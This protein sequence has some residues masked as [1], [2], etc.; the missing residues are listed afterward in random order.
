MPNTIIVPI[1]ESGAATRVLPFAVRLADATTSSIAL[2]QAIPDEGLREHAEMALQRV[3]WH[4]PT[5]L[6]CTMCVRVGSP[7]R[8]IV[9]VA[10]EVHACLI[11][12]ATQHPAEID[13]W[14]NGSIADEVL[15]VARVP[16]LIVPPTM[17]R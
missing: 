4:I 7:T 10:G 12:M 13:R 17:T 9:E 3:A 6:P 1:D 15:R 2:V 14:L 8:V 5:T 11:A 16:V